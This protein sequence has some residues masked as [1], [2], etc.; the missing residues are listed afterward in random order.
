MATSEDAHD[1]TKLL[2]DIAIEQM[3]CLNDSLCFILVTRR[4]G[5]VVTLF[6][7]LL[8]RD[9]SKWKISFSYSFK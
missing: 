3:L 4:N 5:H 1:E 6:C 8:N 2:D 9:K 7:N